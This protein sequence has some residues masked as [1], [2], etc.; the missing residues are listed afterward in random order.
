MRSRR[1]C[2]SNVCVRLAYLGLSVVICLLFS[3][4]L[5]AQG[6]GGRVL[7]RVADPSGAVLSKVMITAINDATGVTHDAL[8]S[9]SGDY[10]FPDLPVGTYSLTFDR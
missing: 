3:L 5:L 7:G 1:A 2:W 10:V 9:D 4:P 6:T 8:T